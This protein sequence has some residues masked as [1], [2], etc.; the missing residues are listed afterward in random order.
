M[1]M[2][3]HVGGRKMIP[4]VF[5]SS[6]FYDLR[7]VREDLANF[8]RNYS[9]DPI[10]FEHGDVGYIYG[11]NLDKSCYKEMQ[12]ADMVVLIIGGRYGSPASGEEEFKDYMSVTRKEFNTAVGENIPIYAFVEQN[13]LSE[14]N[15]YIKN[16]EIFEKESIPF[17]FAATDNV[18]VFHFIEAI[19]M[20]KY[21][22]ITAFS[23]TQDIKNFLKKQWADMFKEYLLYLRK[24]KKNE[25]VLDSVNQLEKLVREMNVMIQKT[26]EKVIGEQTEEL[27]SVVQEQRIESVVSIIANSIELVMRPQ[28]VEKIRDVLSKLVGNIAEGSR[29]NILIRL[30]SQDEEDIEEEVKE[31][32]DILEDAADEIFIG[33]VKDE[34]GLLLEPYKNEI[35]NEKLRNVIVEK[36]MTDENL[37]KMKI[38]VLL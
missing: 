4:R 32:Y 34:I 11:E 8:I 9:F 17:K 38:Q 15:V 22:T 25:N 6:T 21:V 37:K 29:R 2:I 33:N 14:Y 28:E 10:L 18:N 16:K 30:L 23:E 1:S 5:V 19:Y 3:C 7:F 35:E 26:G 13:V 12:N 36:L 31:V 24:D 27:Q 20:L